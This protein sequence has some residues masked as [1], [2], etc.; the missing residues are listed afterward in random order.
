RHIAVDGE[1]ARGQQDEGQR[2][3][4]REEARRERR[5]DD[6]AQRN[7]SAATKPS[8]AAHGSKIR[9]TGAHLP[10]GTRSAA[11]AVRALLRR[12]AVKGFIPRF[13]PL[14]PHAAQPRRHPAPPGHRSP[15]G[16]AWPCTPARWR[17]CENRLYRWAEPA[18]GSGH[19]RARPACSLGRRPPPARRRER[20]PARRL[21][22]LRP[23]GPASIAPPFAGACRASCSCRRRNRRAR[24]PRPRPQAPRR[25]RRR[26]GVAV[27]A[28]LDFFTV[29][30]T[31]RA[32]RRFRP[33]PVS[34]AAIRRILAAATRAPSARGAEPWF[35]V[36]VRAAGTRVAIA[37]RYRAAWEA[38]ERFTAATDADRDLRGRPH[39]ARMMRAARALAA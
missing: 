14:E 15:R 3:G 20:A 10:R 36:V 2:E 21:V 13:R 17:A 39:Y 18:K 35:F 24:P 37:A 38:G 30:D 34:D 27:G 7:P 5:G 22:R 9:A 1:G 32:L 29:V 6:G 12:A 31:Q 33:D 23:G 25:S 28:P 19:P 4:G 11:W 26:G 8:H 16:G